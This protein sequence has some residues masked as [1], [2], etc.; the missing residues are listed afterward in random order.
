MALPT[1]PLD[2]AWDTPETAREIRQIADAERKRRGE[3]PGVAPWLS[4]RHPFLLKRRRGHHK[5]WRAKCCKTGVWLTRWCVRK[6]NCTE[7]AYAALAR[8][9]AEPGG[10]VRSEG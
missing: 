5:S 8:K 1:D 9:A 7:A 10:G 6:R 3:R 2:P 4:P